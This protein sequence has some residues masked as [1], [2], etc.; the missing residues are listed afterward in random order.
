MTIKLS[1]DPDSCDEELVAHLFRSR[2]IGLKY[3]LLWRGSHIV[4]QHFVPSCIKLSN[5]VL[6]AYDEGEIPY[7]NIDEFMNLVRECFPGHWPGDRKEWIIK[8]WDYFNLNIQKR[9]M[10]E[11]EHTEI[12][13]KHESV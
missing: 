4:D 11:Y 5:R 13:T 6:D 9:V 3:W 8:N 12:V 2:G 1:F 7:D 10:Y